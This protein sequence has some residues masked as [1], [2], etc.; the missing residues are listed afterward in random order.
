M[1]PA[2]SGHDA[3]ISGLIAAGNSRLTYEY[4]REAER[5]R[6]RG[7]VALNSGRTNE[8]E[9][10]FAR[11]SKNSLTRSYSTATATRIASPKL[12]NLAEKSISGS[13]VPL[14]EKA[15]GRWNRDC[16]VLALHSRVGLSFSGSTWGRCSICGA[17]DYECTHAPGQFYDGEPC[18]REVYRVE[19]DEVSVVQFPDDPRCY[20][21]STDRMIE[22][23]E[24]HLGHKLPQ[25]A[26]PTCEHC[27]ACRGAKDGPAAEDVDQ[28]LWPGSS[29]RTPKAT[30]ER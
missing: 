7:H 12:T 30:V 11:P 9:K 16:G 22:D 14:R 26:V 21:L 28:S 17:E 5:E 23:I 24:A 3:S 13:S 4:E 2:T 10:H 20:R 6:T 8:A 27:S 29:L 25:G 15:P 18:I 1:K 19:L